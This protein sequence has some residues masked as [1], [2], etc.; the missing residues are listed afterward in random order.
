MSQETEPLKIPARLSQETR[1][2][3]D[4]ER[5]I[6]DL[7]S[8]FG[9][10]LNVMFPEAI[11]ENVEAFRS[12]LE[13]SGLAGDV[14]FAAKANKSEAALEVAAAS[15]IGVD[16]SSLYEQRAAL[17]HGVPGG[18]ISLS[19][20]LKDPRLMA[21]AIQQG[22]SIALDSPEEVEQ[23][24]RVCAQV[25]SD[26]PTRVLLRTSEVTSRPTRFGLDRQG[27]DHAYRLLRDPRF[28]VEG[29]SFHLD[30]YSTDERVA[31]TCGAFEELERARS[32]GFTPDVINIGGG[33]RVA[34][35]EPED[36]EAFKRRVSDPTLFFKGQTFG[37]FYPYSSTDSKE[38]GLRKVLG[39]PF[40]SSGSTVAETLREASVRIFV[41][42]GRSLL[43]QAGLTLFRVKGMKTASNGE[44]LVQV[45]GNM[46][47]LSEQW[48]GTDFVPDPI[49]IR[50]NISLPTT[51]I[52]ASVAGNTCME[53]DMVTWRKV[54]FDA[55]PQAGDILVYANTAGYQMDSN[56]TGF[57]RLPLPEK[58]VA[59]R[60]T[61]GQWCWK[62]DEQF[63][64]LD[65]NS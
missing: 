54:N 35:V 20:P 8:G 11:R 58:V 47:H 28:H 3:L 44:K 56:E 2:F 37:H 1:S 52:A 25:L 60:N 59:Y 17:A 13:T 12:V 50:R 10:P 26:A 34:Y 36:W 6:S 45:D 38:A 14:L 5:M 49:L 16:A 29:F 63:S 27:L 40:S 24:I 32:A 21:L 18:K 15:E 9:S 4:E 22:S 23:L 43:D 41:E 31:A 61:Q 7:V 30:G 48:F 39:A 19:G 65:L 51:P 57:H 55:T 33:F 64:F 62:M 42:P 46:N 53:S